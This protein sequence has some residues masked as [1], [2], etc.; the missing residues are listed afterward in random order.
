MST[1]ME[2]EKMTILTKY[3]LIN[4]GCFS[5]SFYTML[6]QSDVI[7]ISNITKYLHNKVTYKVLIKNFFVCFKSSL[8]TDHK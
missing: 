5:M 6:R 8:E 3:V 1:R 7:C 2:I 4:L